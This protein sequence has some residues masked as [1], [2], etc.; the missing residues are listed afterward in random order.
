MKGA[1]KRDW[2]YEIPYLLHEEVAESLGGP[3]PNAKQRWNAFKRHFSTP[4]HV[5]WAKTESPMDPV[6][7]APASSEEL[8]TIAKRIEEGIKLT[9]AERLVLHKGFLMADGASFSFR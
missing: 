4:G 7:E 9:S 8:F 6:L 5:D 1:P 3:H 2:D